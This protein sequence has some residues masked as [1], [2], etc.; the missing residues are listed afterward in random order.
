[1]IYK[2]LNRSQELRLF[3]LA[4]QNQFLI[5]QFVNACL[6]FPDTDDTLAPIA[7]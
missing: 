2:N 6:G 5:G 3:Q 4:A 7:F 1:M